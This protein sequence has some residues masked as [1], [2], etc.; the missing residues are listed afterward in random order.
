MDSEY[1]LDLQTYSTL[2]LGRSGLTEI[3]MLQRLKVVG[4][5]GEEYGGES[6]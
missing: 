6:R 2:L 1:V 5:N 4:W 3:A